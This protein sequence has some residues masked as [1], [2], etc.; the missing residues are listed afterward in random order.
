MKF[1]AYPASAHSGK[2]FRRRRSIAL[3]IAAVALA[4]SV[5]GVIYWKSTH[6]PF[7]STLD[8]AITT[9]GSVLRIHGRNFG[10][11]RGDSRVEFEDIPPTASSYISWSNDLIE[12]RIP[13]NVDTALVRIVSDMGA[14][15]ARMFISRSR[16]PE[17]PGG[18]QALTVGPQ[19]DSLS[20]EG[21]PCGSL[22]IIRGLNFGANRDSANVLFAWSSIGGLSKP[23]EAQSQEY[24]SPIDGDGEYVL[25]SD[26]EIQVLIPDG[27]V[28]GALAV[29]TAKALSDIRYFQ[30]LD[31][32]GTKVYVGKR[33]YAL[34]SFVTFSRV[35]AAGANS[36]YFWM[37]F[38]QESSSQKGVRVL[39]RSS[40]PFVPDYR[41]LAVYRISDLVAN[42]DYTISQNHLVQ[43]YAVETEVNPGKVRLPPAPLP[44]VYG[45]FTKADA[46]VPSDE[47]VI[48]SYAAKVAGKD[49]NHYT[50]ALAMFDALRSTMKYNADATG[51]SPQAAL[52]AGRADSWNYACIYVAA[53]RSLGIPSRP[54]AG[55]VVDDS[56]RTWRHYWA[57]FYIYGLG[58]IPVD[59]VLGSGAQL[60]NF[61][62]PFEDPLHYFGNMDDRH[63]A[64]SRGLIP[65]DR[66]TPD[67]RTISAT[68][69]N[70]M[71][72]MY[73]EATGNLIS[74]T[75]F[76]SD[77][78][79]TGLY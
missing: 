58:W 40:E 5:F 26:K 3:S 17:L 10:Y 44:A 68:R 76:W 64:F 56:L 28:S 48:R 38:P 54:V 60:G 21:G 31:A 75:S 49:K 18:S 14:S 41:G 39:E 62:P 52:A 30:I 37:P 77:V 8:P 16:L 23:N 20:A 32:P 6:I 24:I 15:N 46:F 33:K 79:V 71:Q 61:K 27:A 11:E 35:E 42:K 73:E 22:L 1:S 4:V 69:R 7:I 67:G 53:L 72:S 59:P 12:V 43:V 19:I 45:L 70:S 47:A 74:Y 55:V 50:L 63:I 66:M 34:S 78:E 57:E 36:L 2:R 9:P 13:T 51:T 25:W 65:V 29:R